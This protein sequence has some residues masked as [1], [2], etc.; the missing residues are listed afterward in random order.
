[1]QRLLIE[2]ADNGI[3]MS[4]EALAKAFT[5]FFTTNRG[6]G[7]SGLGLFSSRRVVEEVLGGRITVTSQTGQGTQFQI[8]LPTHPPL[9]KKESK[10]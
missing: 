3:G 7:G 2:V 10:K 4:Q 9:T 5:P 1:M 6:S 8:L